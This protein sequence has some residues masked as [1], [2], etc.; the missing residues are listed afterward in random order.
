LR[1]AQ[2]CRRHLRLATA[3]ATT[4]TGSGK[5]DGDWL[6]ALPGF[7]FDLLLI[8]LVSRAARASSI[9]FSSGSHSSAEV[10]SVHA[11]K[12][13]DFAEAL[14][15]A[16]VAMI[17]SPV[18]LRWQYTLSGLRKAYVM[19]SVAMVMLNYRSASLYK[20]DHAC[21]VGRLCLVITKRMSHA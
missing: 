17:S 18:T 12:H 15:S 10:Q 7:Y 14:I 6:E 2:F 1:E 19:P 5:P 16:L 4:R 8:S 21:R 3:V 11:R 9:Q 13:S 20:I